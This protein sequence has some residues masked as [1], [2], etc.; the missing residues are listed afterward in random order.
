MNQKT[1]DYR[2]QVAEE[3]VKSLEEDPLHWK[4]TW[5]TGARGIPVNAANNR[6]YSGINNFYLRLLMVNNQWQDPRFATFN[7]IK[8][9]AGTCKREPK[10]YRL[11]TGCQLIR[12]KI[13]Q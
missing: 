10:V 9:L 7:Q 12:M 5:N 1:I 13:R 4:K 11:N 3:F 8:M 6:R 2:E